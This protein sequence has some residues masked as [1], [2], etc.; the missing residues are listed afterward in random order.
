MGIFRFFLYPVVR[1]GEQL[2]NSAAAVGTA[3]KAARSKFHELSDRGEVKNPRERFEELVV[4]H[5]WDDA[6]LEEQLV[7]TRRTKFFAMG[8]TVLA[9]VLVLILMTGVP[10]YLAILLVPAALFVIALGLVM[11]LKY[12]LFQEQL[13][14][15]SLVTL[16]K[17]MS[18]ASFWGYVFK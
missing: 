8:S 9:F 18:E 1:A 17:I 2:T 14:R 13:R 11:T 6:G 12:T 10:A 5:A 4:E 16:K 7:A 3:A 15:R